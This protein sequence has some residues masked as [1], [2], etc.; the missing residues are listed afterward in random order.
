MDRH[1]LLMATVR[2]ERAERDSARI[3]REQQDQAYQESLR[4]DQ[5]RVRIDF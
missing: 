5:E 4:K 2:A 3:L 1:E